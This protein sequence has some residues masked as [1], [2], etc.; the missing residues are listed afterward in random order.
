MSTLYQ[1]LTR[2]QQFQPNQFKQM[3]NAVRNSKNPQQLFMNMAQQNPQMNQVMNM[4]QSSG[5][6]P[7]ELFYQLAQ[8]KGVD[9][10]QILNML[11]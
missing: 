3:L 11:Q 7:K 10:N 2:N 8:Q 6:S 5:K 4:I 1:Q 9:P